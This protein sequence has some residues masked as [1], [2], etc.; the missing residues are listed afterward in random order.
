MI[1]KDLPSRRSVLEVT[2]VVAAVVAAVVAVAA[3]V[4]SGGFDGRVVVS[5]PSKTAIGGKTATSPSPT[6]HD[7]PGTTTTTGPKAGQKGKGSSYS[8]PNAKATQSHSTSPQSEGTSTHAPTAGNQ[9]GPSKDTSEPVQPKRSES[10]TVP[11]VESKPKVKAEVKA[12]V[13]PEGKPKTDTT[14][15]VKDE[16]PKEAAPSVTITTTSTCTNN[17]SSNTSNSQTGESNVNS[18]STSIQAR[19]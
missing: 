8:S 13:E 7:V 17:I 18:S 9:S 2:G 3:F 11:V 6:A 1:R 14:A 5:T 16:T 10:K 19:C 12:K 15:E 4:R